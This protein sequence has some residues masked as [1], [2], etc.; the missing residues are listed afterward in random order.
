MNT[1]WLQIGKSHVGVLCSA[2][3]WVVPSYDSDE[4][5]SCMNRHWPYDWLGRCD[6]QHSCVISTYFTRWR[7]TLKSWPSDLGNC[8]P[9]VCCCVV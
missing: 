4:N 5:G 3:G 2:Q 1:R 8:N 7:I 6:G 9:H